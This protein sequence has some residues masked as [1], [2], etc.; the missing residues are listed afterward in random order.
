MSFVVVNFI[1]LEPKLLHQTH[2][3]HHI[4]FLPSR[5]PLSH[6]PSL[7]CML[8][9]HTILECYLQSLSCKIPTSTTLLPWEREVRERKVMQINCSQ[10]QLKIALN[11]WVSGKAA[12]VTQSTIPFPF[13]SRPPRCPPLSFQ[14]N[15]L[16]TC[17]VY[18]WGE[19]NC[20]LHQPPITFCL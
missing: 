17:Q 9:I 6:F 8:L 15:A 11:R 18:L 20:L 12:F 5:P 10:V 19:I 2:I 14:I 3:L 13:P 7:P 1:L 4:F 16:F